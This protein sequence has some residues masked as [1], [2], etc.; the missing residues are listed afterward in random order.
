MK[1]HGHSE[2]TTNHNTN[3]HSDVHPTQ[4]SSIGIDEKV[5]DVGRGHHR[6]I[7][8][9]PILPTVSVSTMTWTNEDRRSPSTPPFGRTAR[10][11]KIEAPQEALSLPFHSQALHLSAGLSFLQ[12]TYS[13]HASPNSSS[14]PHSAILHSRKGYLVTTIVEFLSFRHYLL[15]LHSIR[16][17]CSAR[18]SV[19][20]ILE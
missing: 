11:K 7:I 18:S 16:G 10:R 2:S 8:H 15:I 13:S 14:A 17:D 20:V 19:A 6:P 12:A 9:R 5:P 4:T 1:I 3:S